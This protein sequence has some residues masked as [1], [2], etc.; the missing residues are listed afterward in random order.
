MSWILL[1]FCSGIFGIAVDG[2]RKQILITSSSDGWSILFRTFIYVL[3]CAVLWW[4]TTDAKIAVSN[5]PLFTLGLVV[6]V[7]CELIAQWHFQLAIKELPLSFCRPL[8]EMTV[9]VMIPL[10]FIF[11]HMPLRLDVTGGIIVFILGVCVMSTEGTEEWMSNI[12][13][14]FRIPEIKSIGF[15]V[16]FWSLTTV[17]QKFCMQYASPQVFT[18]FLALG[19]VVGTYAILHRNH[20]SLKNAIGTFDWR[21]FFSGVFTTIMAGMQFSALSSP[22]AH[23]SIVIVLKRIAQFFYLLVDKKAFNLAITPQ[24]VIG[25]VLIFAGIAIIGFITLLPPH[26]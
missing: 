18:L 12:Q 20:V 4:L 6:G 25:N 14:S 15:V 5:V 11:L 22:S 21:Y 16:I 10:S 17:L 9:I 26:G 8:M 19:L 3:P 24:R 1:A 2:L 7:I 23:P 13:Q